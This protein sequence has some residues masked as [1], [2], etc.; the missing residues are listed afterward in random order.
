MNWRA[1][2]IAAIL[3]ALALLS[4]AEVFALRSSAKGNTISEITRDEFARSGHF[5]LPLLCAWCFGLGMLTAHFFWLQPTPTNS[6][7]AINS[8]NIIGQ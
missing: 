5:A 4:I 3:V 8:V 6:E 1:Y 2:T 7:S